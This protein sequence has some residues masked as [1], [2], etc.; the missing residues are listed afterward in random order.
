[1]INETREQRIA[2]IE[3]IYAKKKAEEYETRRNAL[4]KGDLSI[5]DETPLIC[6]K[7]LREVL[8]E[9]LSADILNKIDNV[10]KQKENLVKEK[11]LEAKRN[12]KNE[13]YP[14]RDA[15]AKYG[16]QGAYALIGII[17]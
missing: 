14:L 17:R 8:L 1:M 7:E 13:Q 6:V 3:K 16:A 12:A 10:I 11:R 4:L 2:R 15:Y 9:E 5:L